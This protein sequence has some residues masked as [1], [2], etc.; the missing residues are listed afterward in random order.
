MESINQCVVHCVGCL[1]CGH[2]STLWDGTHFVASHN[3]VVPCQASSDGIYKSVQYAANKDNWLTAYAHIVKPSA[4]AIATIT[5]HNRNKVTDL[6]PPVDGVS[7][8]PEN[9]CQPAQPLLTV[10]SLGT[11]SHPSTSRTGAK[12]TASLWTPLT[13]SSTRPTRTTPSSTKGCDSSPNK[14]PMGIL[15]HALSR[16]SPSHTSSI[17]TRMKWTP[18]SSNPLECP[19][20]SSA[21]SPIT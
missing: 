12:Q 18:P 10:I 20:P 1:W 17:S 19:L 13:S 9:P 11:S 8:I 21:P 16:T 6:I 14:F 15:M 5:K 7:H 3:Q 4:T 2:I